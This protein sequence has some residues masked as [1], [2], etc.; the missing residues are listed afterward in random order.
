MRSQIALAAALSLMATTA[1]AFQEE[2]SA[3]PANGGAA[4]AE[5]ALKPDAG[6]TVVAIP[7]LGKLGVIPKL[8]FGLEL[9]YGDESQKLQLQNDEQRTTVRPED[10]GD[11]LRIRGSIK[12]RF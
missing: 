10:D 8:D 6:G 1:L 3:K 2:K 5:E 11:G 9:L 12:H 4:L 7:G